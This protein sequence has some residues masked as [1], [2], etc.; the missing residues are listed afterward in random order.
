[1]GPAWLGEMWDGAEYARE[2]VPTMTNKPLT[3][4]RGIGWQW[5]QG[6]EVQDYEGDKQEIP[7]N[8]ISTEPLEVNAKR[9]AVGH[10]IDRA[11]FDFNETEF[12]E[13]FFT[14]RAN[15][16]AL[17]TDQKAAEFLVES[18]HTGTTIEQEPDLLH[19][20]ARGRLTIKQQTRVEP[21]AFLVNPGDMSHLF[22][23]WQSD[24]AAYLDLLG[25]DPATCIA[26]DAVPAG[27]MIVYA[28]PAAT[29][30]EL[31]GS[32]IRVDA[33]R[34]THGGI[35]SAIF[36]YYASLLNNQNGIVSVPFGSSEVIAEG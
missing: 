21:T 6:P 23:S 17:K 33:E 8:E 24:T 34:I 26:T 12:L 36:G 16:Y 7:T 3:S 31:P 11:Y 4:M 19:A 18:A 2:I 25:L 20:A 28:R 22:D 30:F 15:D 32:P 5:V 27:E 9:L 13:S 29:F 35:D 1:S 10:D 14:A